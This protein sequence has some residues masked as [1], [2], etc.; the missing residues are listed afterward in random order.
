MSTDQL[1]Q[2]I[3]GL[4]TAVEAAVTNPFEGLAL[5]ALNA[6]IDALLPELIGLLPADFLDLSP[7]D[8]V[9]ALFAALETKLAGRPVLLA[10]AR[11]ANKII[12]SL[13]PMA[14]QK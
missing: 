9:D 8:A 3:D 6:V 7:T 2:W 10:L 11:E 14:L 12:D 13:L 5:K 1:K 4:F